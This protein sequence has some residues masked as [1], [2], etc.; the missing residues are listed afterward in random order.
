MIK[1]GSDGRRTGVVDT[2]IASQLEGLRSL[3][4]RDLRTEWQ[5]LYRAPAPR[6][7]RDL[8]LRGVAYRIQ[9]LACGGL[10][11]AALRKLTSFE[12]E[13][14]EK[15]DLAS[16]SERAPLRPG[17]RLLRE[18]RGRTHA[19]IVVENG[20]EYAGS[21][22]PSLTKIAGEITGAHWSGPR[23]FGLLEKR[24]TSSGASPSDLNDPE[25]SAA[26]ERPRSL[27]VTGG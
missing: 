21:I 26:G 22:Y 23:F 20:F 5:R 17:T 25:A 16:V 2:D 12:K 27:E 8:L 10:S 18:W 14:G 13:L 9:E 3:G 6:L 4:E 19:V 11:K 24:V 15:G 1:S 7:S